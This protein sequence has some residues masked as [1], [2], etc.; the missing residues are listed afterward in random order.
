MKSFFVFAFI[1]TLVQAEPLAH[2]GKNPPQLTCPPGF[3]L[4]GKKCEQIITQMPQTICPAG[5]FDG[6]ACA[7]YTQTQKVCPPGSTPSGKECLADN[8]TPAQGTCPPGYTDVGKSGCAKTKTLPLV[9]FCEAGVADG[10]GQCVVVET[11]EKITTTHCPAGY[12]DEGK[13]CMQVT[14]YD[15]SPPIHGKEA[16]RLPPPPMP[17]PIFGGYKHKKRMLGAKKYG[18]VYAPVPVPLPPPV[19]VPVPAPLPPPVVLPPPPPPPKVAVVQQL[20]QRKDFANP[21]V[22]TKCPPGYTEV[23]KKCAMK[24]VFPPSQKCANGLPATQCA[25]TLTAPRNF[26]C[27]NG[28]ILMGDKCQHTSSYPFEIAC[29][30]GFQMLGH[31][32]AQ[33]VNPEIVC[34]AGLVLE[35]NLCIG[36]NYAEPTGVKVVQ[37]TGKGCWQNV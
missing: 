36:R 13:G 26:S 14:Q 3:N 37:C 20:C 16:I 6:G 1:V 30:A 10:A 4:T 9:D 5:T 19:P 21:I 24:K 34:P 23:G 8:Y 27:P 25:E 31:Q 28:G 33:F 11:S 17:V 7:I 22:E 32:C 2:L 35:G 29:P 15:C 18:P 12:I